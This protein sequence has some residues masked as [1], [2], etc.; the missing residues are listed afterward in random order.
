MKPAAEGWIDDHGGNLD[1]ARALHPNAPE[2][3]VDLSTGINPHAYP[4]S[5]LPA[6]AFSRLP[7]Q[8]R[9]AELLDVAATAYGA[10]SAAH[11]TAA[12]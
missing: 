1:R 6:T 8:S 9:L 12:P 5:A 2:S 7:E 4:V 3:W 11:V 10:P